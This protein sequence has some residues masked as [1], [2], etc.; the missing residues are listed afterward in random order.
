VLQPLGMQHN[1]Y[2]KLKYWKFNNQFL[3]DREPLLRE[4]ELLTFSYLSASFKREKAVVADRLLQKIT[5]F[6][7]HFDGEVNP[8]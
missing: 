7:V 3:L 4:L 2:L 8:I 6:M 1:I 5:S